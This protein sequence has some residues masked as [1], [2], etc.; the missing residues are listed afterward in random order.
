MD[1]INYDLQG[2]VFNIQRYS[3]HDGPGIRTIVFLKGCP[4]S[5]KWCSNPESQNPKPELIF[6]RESC[7]GCGRCERACSLGAIKLDDPDRIDRTVCTG[8]GK[9]QEACVAGALEK[10]GQ[11]M[12]VAEV[13]CELKK[14]AINF[15]RSGGGITLSGGEPLG[16]SDFAAELLKACQAQGWHTAMETTMFAS[17]QAVRKVMPY[18]DLALMDVKMMNDTA[19]LKYTGQSNVPIHR[20]AG[21]AAQMTQVVIRV[22]LI[23]NVNNSADEIRSICSYAKKLRGIRTIHLLPY[24]TY[25]E[26]K[27][28][29]LGKN[30]EM[31]GVG[32]MKTEE[33]AN[34]QKVVEQEGFRCIIGG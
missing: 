5:C 13:I 25:G 23:P 4:L 8:C 1:V 14:D 31:R 15:R 9:C 22:P 30:Y 33:A 7:I 20:N 21:I 3:L 11:R 2:T 16:Q 32:D 17:E 26:N 27:Y 19:H 28:G 24:H 12:T 18:L 10:K 6:N 29:L 34:L